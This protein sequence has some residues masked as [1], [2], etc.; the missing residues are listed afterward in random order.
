MAEE[1][2]DYLR[3]NIL[4]KGYDTNMFIDFLK[5][6]KG[7]DGENIDNWTLEDLREVVK[8]FTSL[9]ENPNPVQEEKPEVKKEPEVEQNPP[10]LTKTN[11]TSNDEPGLKDEEFGIVIPDYTK[12]QQIEKS[13]LSKYDNIEIK[14]N[15]YKLVDN[16]FFSKSY[17]NF[18][19]ETKPLNYNVNRR[20]SDFEWLK[21]KLSIIFNTSILPALCKKKKM[22]DESKINR[23]M[24]ELEQFLNYLLKDPLIR[25]SKIFYDFIFIEND[26]E[27]HKLKKIYD[28]LKTPVELKDILTLNENSKIS[29]TSNKEKYVEYIRD[30]AGF[31]ETCLKRFDQ[32]FKD[33]KME[34]EVVI[35]RIESF[36]PLF[37]KLIKIGTKYYDDNTT[38]ESYKQMKFLF[39]SYSGILKQQSAFFYNDVKEH[40]RF[41]SDTFHNTKELTLAVE[42]H[43]ANYYKLSKNLIAKKMELF[44]KQDTENWQLE[45]SDRNDLVSFYKDKAICYK[46][47]LHKDTNNV[48]KVKEKYGFYLN[49]MI[50]EYERMRSINASENKARTILFSLKQQ[51]IHS[52]YIQILEKIIATL[53]GCSE[54]KS[55]DAENTKN[56]DPDIELNEEEST[57]K[58]K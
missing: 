11:N 16:G 43:K 57:Q 42:T 25:N 35:N 4:E 32:N 50:S 21:E 44:K 10:P 41:M 55:K 48:I 47:I 24:R 3:E 9:A 15:S 49:R 45:L 20:Y 39:E 7:E 5:S 40:L 51:K 53:N 2:Q 13:E 36:I 54:G 18:Q 8:E 56:I 52:D 34:I 27:F 29:V 33:L 38:I 26:E 6:K 30:N 37:N 22:V 58:E 19:I 12:C 17:Y 31:N 46:K 23:R 14:I 28:R 1:K